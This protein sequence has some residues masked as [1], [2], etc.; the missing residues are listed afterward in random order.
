[1]NRDAVN[2]DAVKEHIVKEHVVKVGAVTEKVD[3][4]ILHCWPLKPA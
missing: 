1:M 2:R 4:D 3:C